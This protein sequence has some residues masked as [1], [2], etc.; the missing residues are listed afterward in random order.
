MTAYKDS[1]DK[2]GVDSTPADLVFKSTPTTN[3]NYFEIPVTG[4][5]I[6]TPYDFNFQWVY[7]DG[8]VGS[9]SPN[10]TVTTEG[11]VTK[12]TKPTITIE[13]AALGYIVSYTKQTDPNFGYIIV[14]EVVSNA[15]TAPAS[16]WIEVAVSSSNPVIITVGNTN[17]RWVRARLIDKISGNTTYSDAV[18]ITPIDPVAAALDTTPPTTAS[19]V[20]AVWSGDDVLI[21]ATVA[22]D[23]KKF[24]VSLTNGSDTRVFT[25]F[26]DIA[27]TSQSIKILESDLYGA[28]G[29]YPTSFTGTLV[30]ADSFDNR[31]SGANFV[32]AQKANALSGVVPT[33]VLTGITN[34]YT[35]TWTLPS[36]ASYAKVYESASS[37]GVGNPT[38]ADLVFSGLSP[39]IIKKT[40]YTQR[41]VKILYLTKDGSV[42]SWSAEQTVTPID[43]IAADVIA[44]SAPSTVATPTSGIDTSGTLGFNGY[45]DL[46]WTAI[47]DSTLRGY[48]IRFRPSTTPASN[49]SYVDSPGTGTSYRLGGLSVG[50][51]YEI[52][53]ASYDEFNNTTSTYTSFTNTIISG[54][55]S[56]SN[57]ITSGAAGFQFGSGIKNSSGNQDATAQGIY[58][59][60]NNYWYL[61]SANAAQFKIGGS[62]S[63]YVSWNG[64]K[65]SVDGDLGVAGGTTIGGNIAMGASGASIYQ[66]TLSSGNLTSDGFLLNSSGLVIKKGSVQLRLDTSDGGIYADYGRIAGWNIDSSKLEKLN[67]GTYSGISSTGTYAF[68]AGGSSGGSGTPPFKVTQTGQ[69]TASSVQITGGTLDVGA[70]WPSGFHVDSNGNLK[71][72]NAVLNGEINASTGTI[73]NININSGGLYIGSSATTGNRIVLDSGGIAA[74]ASGVT[75]P[76]FELNSSGTAKI[77]GWTINADSLS[78][79]GMQLNSTNQTITFTQGFIID[80]DSTYFDQLTVSDTGS[81]GTGTGDG[82]VET[83]FSNPGSATTTT[84]GATF[85]IKPSSNGAGPRLSLSTSDSAVAIRSGASSSASSITVNSTGIVLQAGTA[86]GIVFKNFTNKYHYS[87]NGNVVAAPLMIK[88]DGTLSV[89]RAIYKSGAS[90]TSIITNGTHNSVGLVGDLMFSTSD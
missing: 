1:L 70:S 23:V 59:N 12:L 41:Y 33:F 45:I 25:K 86:G 32:V 84:P 44:P 72:A 69:L 6:G 56:L 27:G 62:T 71:A 9:W 78:S 73:G 77:G 63:N 50:A 29:R 60:N 19:A 75:S 80:Q 46:S 89:G 37:W 76:K 26:P 11:Y 83:L 24:I 43:A 36:G 4:L 15:L 34:G 22:A 16:G 82:D 21:T 49:Y 54:T 85:S 68:Y 79:S 3:K 74:Y 55:P 81:S 66:G 64:T 17:R 57:Y 5:K 67:S 35:A 13:A 65:L 8:T 58:L 42:S 38:E 51:T 88:P 31:D 53:I 28:F 2:A 10:F 39:A 48:R 61:T 20:S 30:S 90:E 7:P 47:S 40:V 14:E 18:A 87:Y 52:G